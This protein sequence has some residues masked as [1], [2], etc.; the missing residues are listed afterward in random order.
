MFFWLTLLIT[1]EKDH[2]EILTSEIGHETDLFIVARDFNKQRSALK[3]ISLKFRKE[4]N[5]ILMTLPTD[6][7][8]AAQ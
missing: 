1:N 6:Y 3:M 7:C 2:M 4:T 5:R 8:R